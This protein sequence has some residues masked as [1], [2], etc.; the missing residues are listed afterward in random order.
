[1][2]EDCDGFRIA[3]TCKPNDV[4]EAVKKLKAEDIE[5]VERMG[6]GAFL[7]LTLQSVCKPQAIEWMMRRA[8]NENGRIAIPIRPDF[9]LYITP[10]E[11]YQL[12]EVPRGTIPPEFQRE[13]KGSME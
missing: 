12:I 13:T 6:F 4:I 11:I 10:E 8:V 3:V 9:T 7:K 2:D 5:V 1:M